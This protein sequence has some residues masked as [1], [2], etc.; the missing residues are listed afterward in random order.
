MTVSVAVAVG[1][2]VESVETIGHIVGSFKGKKYREKIRTTH[3]VL[4]MV[5]NGGIFHKDKARPDIMH[6]KRDF[7]QQLKVS[8]IPGPALSLDHFSIKHLWDHL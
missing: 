5:A 2:V 6:A 4:Y 3:V 7:L 8:V 1:F